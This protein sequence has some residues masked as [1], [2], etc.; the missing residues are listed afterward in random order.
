[1]VLTPRVIMHSIMKFRCIVMTAVLLLFSQLLPSDLLQG[2][3]LSIATSEAISSWTAKSP[4]VR[5]Y[6]W[7]SG[8][9]G[10]LRWILS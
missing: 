7:Q 10:L 8:I 6:V 2:D 4:S 5:H 1:M 9:D 3:E